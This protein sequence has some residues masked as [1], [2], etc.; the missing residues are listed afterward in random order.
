MK[1]L[2]SIFLVI[3]LIVVSCTSQDNHNKLLSIKDLVNDEYISS[4]IA[5]A[6][7]LKTNY[8]DKKYSIKGNPYWRNG[9]IIIDGTYGEIRID[10]IPPDVPISPYMLVARRLRWFTDY[11]VTKDFPTF[12][13]IKTLS[14]Q[15]YEITPE[16]FAAM[17]M[18]TRA[19]FR[20]N[21]IF[22]MPQVS[23]GDIIIFLNKT[24]LKEK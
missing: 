12:L 11:R 20:E 6:D 13:Y 9:Y 8:F 4:D 3:I 16:E 21:P 2:K 7:I 24:M 5:S 23:K 10:Y 22:K 17:P 14:N 19:N 1:V 18:Q 15:R